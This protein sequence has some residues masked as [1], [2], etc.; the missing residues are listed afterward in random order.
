M[1]I[2]FEMKPGA[3][4]GSSESVGE[5]MDRTDVEPICFP[6]RKNGKACAARNP[7]RFRKGS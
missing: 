2:S 4:Q 5:M 6:V 1:K 3:G 7:T